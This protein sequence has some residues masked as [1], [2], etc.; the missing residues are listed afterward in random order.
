MKASGK[1]RASAFPQA[2]NARG[3]D[4]TQWASERESKHATH[5][6]THVSA[7]VYI[8]IYT[9]VGRIGEGVR[10]QGATQDVRAGA[11]AAESREKRGV[12]PGD[13]VTDWPRDVIT[14][15]I[16]SSIVQD[17]LDKGQLPFSNSVYRR[18]IDRANVRTFAC[19][20]SPLPR[21]PDVDADA[22]CRDY[23]L[24][25]SFASAQRTR[26]KAPRENKRDPRVHLIMPRRE[27]RTCNNYLGQ[28]KR[29][30]R[31]IG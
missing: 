8:Y 3:R 21:T 23:Q 18:Y 26:S 12:F 6:C 9:R 29:Y 7:Y 22:F 10:G 27:S 5:A 31:S 11:A 14:V 25:N 13:C 17:N 28:W 20:M 16:N 2:R 4:V 19:A 1:P 15:V 30:F 24:G